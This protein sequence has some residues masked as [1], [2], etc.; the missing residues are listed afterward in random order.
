MNDKIILANWKAYLSPLKIDRWLADFSSGYRKIDGIKVVLAVPFLSLASVYNQCRS[1]AGVTLAAQDVSSFPQ[2]SYTGTI[3]AA[4]LAGMCEYVLVGHR[5]R[6][7]Y[8]HETV[9]DI[10]NKI[11]ECVEDELSPVLCINRNDFARQFAAVE[12]KAKDHL[13]LAYTPDE[14]EF[15]EVARTIE[16]VSEG[17]RYFSQASGRRPVFYGGGV[18]AGNVAKFI[19]LPEAAGVMTASG[20]LD[21]RDFLTLL[22]NAGQ[23]LKKLS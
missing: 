12:T 5:E 11:S 2:G 8:F 21:P 18:N 3:P 7:K 15:L 6:R 23:A 9:Q 14:A 13:I 4:W 10:A 17:I 1:M 22:G 19:N 20:C 16:G